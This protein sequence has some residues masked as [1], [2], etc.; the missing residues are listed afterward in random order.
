MDPTSFVAS[1]LTL[2]GAAGASCEFLYNFILDIS[3]LPDEIHS[4]ARKLQC[5]K[6]SISNLIKIYE[7][8]AAPAEVHLDPFLK[9]QLQIFLHETGKI[10]TKI[11]RS[12]FRLDQSRAHHL[13]ESLLWISSNRRM[14]KFYSTLDDWLKIFSTAATETQMYVIK[15]PTIL[16]ACTNAIQIAFSQDPETD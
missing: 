11:R 4:Q 1:V 2:L 6:L 15:A 16:M 5:L 7:Q 8:D 12:S 3:E 10:E 9:A 13:R 14:R